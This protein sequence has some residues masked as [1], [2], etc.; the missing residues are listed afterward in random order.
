[1]VALGLACASDEEKF[2][3][4]MKNADEYL[5]EG[6]TKEAVLE[7][8]SALKINPKSAE[9]NE[10]IAMVYKA[11]GGQRDAAFFY[12][13]AYRLDPERIDA[14]MEEAQLLLFS[15]PE[16]TE[17]IIRKVNKLEDVANVRDLAPFLTLQSKEMAGITFT[18]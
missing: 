16:R 14:A 4:H 17:E 3:E 2:A 15:D 5:D 13:E 8:R 18:H 9:V 10:R 12:R 7:F 1:M 11:A 6:K